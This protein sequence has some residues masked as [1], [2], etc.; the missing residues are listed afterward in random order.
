MNRIL[1]IK[2]DYSFVEPQVWRC[3]EVFVMGWRSTAVAKLCP[4]IQYRIKGVFMVSC[5]S[6]LSEYMYGLLITRYVSLSLPSLT[7]FA[8]I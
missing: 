5:D 3:G 6:V 8:T 1:R 4:G 7:L 2:L